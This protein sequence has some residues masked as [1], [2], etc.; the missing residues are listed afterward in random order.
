MFCIVPNYNRSC[1]RHGLFLLNT[2][3][4]V[5]GLDQ[6]FEK[7]SRPP[8]RRQMRR[9]YMTVIIKLKDPWPSLFPSQL[10]DAFAFRHPGPLCSSN[11]G[12]LAAFLEDLARDWLLVSVSS[13]PSKTGAVH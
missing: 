11:K 10:P 1:S 6:Y 3:I 2:T 8:T 4:I 7:V 12:S 13:E 9:N 5:G